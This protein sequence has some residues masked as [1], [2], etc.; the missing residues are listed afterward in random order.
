MFP[1]TEPLSLYVPATLACSKGSVL[2]GLAE[3]ER[4][5]IIAYQHQPAV[6]R[7]SPSTSRSQIAQAISKS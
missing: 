7:L 4:A 2:G 6:R 5:L 3:F 1:V